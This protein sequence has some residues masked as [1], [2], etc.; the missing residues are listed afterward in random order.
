MADREAIVVRSAKDRNEP[1]RKRVAAKADLDEIIKSQVLWAN[2][3]VG[4]DIAVDETGQPRIKQGAAEVRIWLYFHEIFKPTEADVLARAQSRR[5]SADEA[6]EEINRE[7]GAVDDVPPTATE[8]DEAEEEINRE[9]E[10]QVKRCYEHAEAL[11][12]RESGEA[13][14]EDAL[15]KLV[16]SISARTLTALEK[17]IRPHISHDPFERLEAEKLRHRK[18][19]RW[20]AGKPSFGRPRQSGDRRPPPKGRRHTPPAERLR[21]IQ[22]VLGTMYQARDERR[23]PQAKDVAAALGITTRQLRN[24]AKDP[25][26]VRESKVSLSPRLRDHLSS[27]PT[28]GDDN[29]DGW[30]EE[31]L[32]DLQDD[33]KI[34]LKSAREFL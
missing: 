15:L 26:T 20:R 13:T 3:E 16:D 11:L 25:R 1:S 29:L 33:H 28:P 24:W 5:L 21:R 7:R 4:C 2:K 30:L 32:V 27:W 6:E 23:N 17:S 14:S 22:E 10:G 31:L 12:S 9:S 34:P 19:D 8:R 18:H